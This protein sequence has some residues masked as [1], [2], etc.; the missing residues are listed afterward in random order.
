MARQLI[1]QGDEVSLL[2]LVEPSYNLLPADC[3]PADSSVKG[4]CMHHS[5]KLAAMQ[6]K[7]KI[8]YFLQKTPLVFPYIKDK[9]IE[10][11]KIALCRTYLF[12]RQPLPMN[13][14]IFYTYSC[15]ARQSLNLYKPQPYPGRLVIFQTEKIPDDVQR[16]WSS[17]A[18]ERT[19]IHEI[20]GAEHLTI[21]KEPYMSTLSRQLNGYLDQIQ[22]KGHDQKI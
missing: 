3:R 2:C 12:F 14:E 5:R 11:M 6:S 13:L 15:Y 21:I 8:I 7:D 17:I 9:V 18:S 16:D 1:Q 22:A 20:P 19:E 4:I 10:K